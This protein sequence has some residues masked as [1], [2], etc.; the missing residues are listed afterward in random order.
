[1]N[2]FLENII[3]VKN[4]EKHFSKNLIMSVE[5]EKNDKGWICEKVFTD[6]DEKVRDHDHITE[7]FRGAAHSDCNINLKLTKKGPILIHNLRVMMVIW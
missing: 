6:K 1:M 4:Y 7:I 5:D 3:I 2:Q